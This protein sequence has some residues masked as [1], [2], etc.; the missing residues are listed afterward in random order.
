M[1]FKHKLLLIDGHALF[2]RAFHALP[3]MSGPQ[4]FPTGAIFGF[5]SMLFKAFNDIKPT[6]ALVTFDV[7]GPTF[8]DKLAADYKATRKAPPD[9]LTIQLP[10]LKEILTALDIPIYEKE[11]YEADD[12]LGIIAHKTPKDVLN[13]IV[14][15]DLDLLQLINGRTEVYRFKIGFSDIQIFDENKMLE[16]YGLRP[17]QWVD[18]KAI[19]GDVSDNIPGVPG[20][21]EKGALELIKKFGSLDGV[22]KAAEAKDKNIKPGTLKKLEEGR[23]KAYLSK[24]L[25]HIDQIG[26]LSLSAKGGSASGGNFDFEKTKIGDYDQNKVV[27][28]LKELE[29]KA[30]INRLPK[31]S[32]KFAAKAEPKPKVKARPNELI[33]TSEQAQLAAYLINPGLRI[34]EER[35]WDGL[36]EELKAK[37]LAKIFTEI[38]VLLREVLDDMQK[39]GIKLDI[40]YLAKLSKEADKKITELTRKIHKL[41]GEE[42][43]ISSPIQLREVLF[44]KLKISFEGL[45]KTGKTKA[46]STAAEQLEKLR[47]LHPIVE[48]IF[49]YREL[50]KLKSTYLDALPKLVAKDGRLHTQYSQTVAATG[51]ISSSEPNLQNI[52]IRTE[53]GNQIRKAFVADSGF[54]LASLD[55]SQIELRIAASLSND[56]EM[57]KIFQNGID[58]HT[59][60]ASKI[61]NVK[62]EEVTPSQRRDAKTINFSVLYGVSGFGLSERSEMSRAEAL[63]FIKKYFNV[64]SKLKEYIDK[65]IEQAHK[66]GFAVNPLGR[67]RYFPEINSSNFAI[68]SAAER[69]A[70]NMPIQSLAADI[71]KMAMIE[72]ETRN[73][74]QET[75]CRMLLTVHDELVFEIKPDKVDQFVPEIKKI[76]ESVYKLKVPIVVEAKIGPNWMEMERYDANNYDY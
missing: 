8:R 61:F 1:E 27:G 42:F 31:V 51:R 17:S 14:T 43:N 28:L 69:A 74:E 10:K 54:V 32:E 70:V 64:F 15:G 71:L 25:A 12:L 44:D 36:A 5:L 6:H 46:L 49:E 59:A 47:G 62:P 72:I 19:R 53:L 73:K 4:G 30:L 24:K 57:I 55:Y 76:M 2:H 33:K 3:A 21:G 37:N 39:R 35:D 7:P 63:E 23:E 67:I 40:G 75:N 20:I 29:I 66:E 26:E 45:R 52:P 18:Y 50:T 60:T 41:A 9:D 13:I 22:Y 68:R 16:V 65:S 48:L 38:E 58:F 34:Y 56:P 11:G